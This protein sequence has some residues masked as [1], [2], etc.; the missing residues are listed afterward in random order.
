MGKSTLALN[1]ATHVAAEAPVAVFTLEMSREEIIHRLASSLASVD[2][3]KIKT[4]N[5]DMDQWRLLGQASSRLFGL[6]MYV[7]DGAALTVT[8]IRPSADASSVARVWDWSWST[9]S[10]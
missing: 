10:N 8:A 7:D 4:G 6:K 5:L 2:S 9:I 3:S 1:I